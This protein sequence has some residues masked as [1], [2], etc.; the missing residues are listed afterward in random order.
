M[1]K[2][3]LSF[4]IL[5]CSVIE[6]IAQNNIE[7]SSD[8][9]ALVSRINADKVLMYFDTLQSPKL[10]YSVLDKDYYVLLGDEKSYK[11]YYITIDSVGKIDEVRLLKRTKRENK[12]LYQL[13]PFEILK[14]CQSEFM[15]KKED[16]KYV[17]GNSSYFVVK[18]NDGKRYG[19]FCLS[20]F[21]LPIP[22]D[23]KLYGYLVRRLS[24]QISKSPQN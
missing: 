15:T 7:K 3:V 19:E 18:D 21:T 6:C 5:F 14:H 4:M 1:K 16:A 10:L 9:L 22:I 11:E 17:R 13:K 8:S 20:V 2:F 23:G 12:Q 24:E